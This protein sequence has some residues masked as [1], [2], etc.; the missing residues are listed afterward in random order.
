M[1]ANVTKKGQEMA[2]KFEKLE[3]FQT[4]P[5]KIPELYV[6]AAAADVRLFS[7]MSCERPSLHLTKNEV[8]S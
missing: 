6:I 1:V 3:L 2:T 5:I 4:S 8:F 7:C